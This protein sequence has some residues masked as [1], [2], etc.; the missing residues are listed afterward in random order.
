MTYPVGEVGV[1][2]CRKDTLLNGLFGW[3]K[4]DETSGTTC[5]D[6]SGNSN[7]GIIDGA[8]INQPGH[9]GKCYS[10]DGSNDRVTISASLSLGTGD[11]SVSCWV[12]TTDTSGYRCFFCIGE[13]DPGFYLRNGDQ[14]CVY[15]ENDILSDDNLDTDDGTWHHVAIVREGTGTDELKFYLDGTAVGTATHSDSISNANTLYIGATR[16]NDEVFN[17]E[18]DD[19]RLYTR[20]LTSAEVQ[21]LADM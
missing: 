9:I 14:V 8:T 5:E 4:L 2:E 3:W 19:V 17:G 16:W 18:L 7:D 15:D 20:A 12:K 13:Y 21:C 10:F 6:F 11:Y 1:C